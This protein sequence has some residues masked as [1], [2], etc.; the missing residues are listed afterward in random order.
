MRLL[1]CCGL[2]L[3]WVGLGWAQTVLRVGQKGG[4]HSGAVRIQGSALVFEDVVFEGR[5]DV[6]GSPDVTF[7]GCTFRGPVLVTGS[8]RSS[9]LDNH[10]DFRGL[11]GE[12]KGHWGYAEVRGGETVWRRN[13][14][15]G[16]RRSSTLVVIRHGDGKDPRV[17][18]E[19]FEGTTWWPGLRPLDYAPPRDGRQWWRTPHYTDTSRS[20]WFAIDVS[21]FGRSVEFT[22]NTVRNTGVAGLFLAYIDGAV[23]RDNVGVDCLDYTFGAEWCRNVLME[24]NTSRITD[25]GR[26]MFQ[27]HDLGAT[28]GLAAMYFSENVTIRD[29]VVDGGGIRLAANGNP[30]LDVTISGNRVKRSD[31]YVFSWARGYRLPVWTERL[32]VVGNTVEGGGISLLNNWTDRPWTAVRGRVAGNR[33]KGGR[34]PFYT[35]IRVQGFV[36]TVEGNEVTGAKLPLWDADGLLPRS[37]IVDRN[38]VIDGRRGRFAHRSGEGGEAR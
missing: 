20:V 29:N 37:Q 13:L 21:A 32:A 8:P 23:I 22:G 19:E 14:I 4:V 33:V 6:I 15:E 38:N 18:R 27:G 36:G 7:R 12:V 10:F 1:L 5:V 9:F 34:S 35:G 2:V 17:L 25:Q 11:S 28:G 16:Q 31:I 24:R 26:A 3:G 30:M